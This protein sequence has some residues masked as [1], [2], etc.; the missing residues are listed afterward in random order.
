MVDL[1]IKK[2]NSLKNNRYNMV[3][4]RYFLILFFSYNILTGQQYFTL[5]H[6]GVTREYY[7]SYPEAN[8]EPCP[9]IINMHGFGGDA[10]GQYYYSQMDY[11]ALPL[12][13]AVVYPEGINNS[14]NVG[15]FWDNNTNDDIGF[16]SC[17]IDTIASDFEIDLERVYACGMSNGG[18]MAYELACELSDKI[19]AFGSV[20][21]NFMLNTEQFN[22]EYQV[23]EISYEVPIIHLHGDLDPI[24]NYYPPSFDGALTISESIDYWTDINGLNEVS[25]ATVQGS[26]YQHSAEKFV[27]HRENTNAKF[28]HYRII[29]G[30]HE[31]FGSPYAY[32]SVISANQELINFFLEYELSGLGCLPTN[33]D[34]NNDDVVDLLDFTLVLAFLVDPDFPY[35]NV[36]F[37]VNQDGHADIIDLYAVIDLAY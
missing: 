34:F 19:T 36:C 15:T 1:G 8:T 4:Y 22:P 28:I 26:G 37:D 14:W 6:G 35:S 13:I 31:W 21:G 24:V 12:N 33:G 25:S 7:V 29:N 9:L 16:I 18:Y 20:T 23:C 32:P 5:N 17:L 10:I 3:H 11:Y 27:Y 30:G 2:Q